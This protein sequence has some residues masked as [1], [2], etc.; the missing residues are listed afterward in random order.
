[1]YGNTSILFTHALNIWCESAT[2]TVVME[3]YPSHVA[4]ESAFENGSP[5]LALKIPPY[6]V[7][8]GELNDI[9]VDKPL[10]SRHPK[11]RILWT[12]GQH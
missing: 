9:I 10:Y 7:H 2:H 12:L 11:T 3:V 1:M 4:S 6:S 5:T 8:N